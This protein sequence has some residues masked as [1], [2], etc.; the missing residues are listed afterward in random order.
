MSYRAMGISDTDAAI[1]EANTRQ[2][3]PPIW[4]YGYWFWD[5]AGV[6]SKSVCVPIGDRGRA[7]SAWMGGDILP[8][9]TV[10]PWLVDLSIVDKPTQQEMDLVRMMNLNPQ[11]KAA[12][13]PELKIGGSLD[14]KLYWTAKWFRDNRMSVSY[15]DLSIISKIIGTAEANG[16]EAI[17]PSA[18][19][20]VSVASL[21][22]LTS[23]FNP[24][25]TE[26]EQ[27]P[28]WKS[29]TLM[30][31]GF[32]FLFLVMAKKRKLKKLKGLKR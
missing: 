11:L 25:T 16:I 31:A 2:W 8:S 32:G 24:V 10:P 21:T 22:D 29:P 17:D 3:G 5:N 19:D 9:A 1:W 27:L 15:I 18:S 30:L 26:G 6:L 20:L 14:G 13:K 4:K 7:C 12:G 23:A 28:F